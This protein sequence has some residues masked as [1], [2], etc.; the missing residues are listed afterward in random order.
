MIYHMP[1]IYVSRLDHGEKLH[2]DHPLR[3][4][5][6][7]AMSWGEYPNWRSIP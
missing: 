5:R 1:S 6:W 2:S 4:L 3:K 7:P